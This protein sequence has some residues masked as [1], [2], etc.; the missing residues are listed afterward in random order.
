[1]LLCCEGFRFKVYNEYYY[2]QNLFMN[3]ECV[4]CIKF[5]YYNGNN[6]LCIYN[7]AY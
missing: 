4:L 7:I 3:T 2:F 6:K 1:M 5:V